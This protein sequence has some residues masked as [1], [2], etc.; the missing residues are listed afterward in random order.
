MEASGNTKLGAF[1]G[2]CVFRILG[3]YPR[4]GK[5]G[6]K[7]VVKWFTSGD[8]TT[9]TLHHYHRQAAESNLFMMVASLL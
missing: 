3:N 7:T 4:S 6:F 9:V 2:G 5:M 8:I 1:T